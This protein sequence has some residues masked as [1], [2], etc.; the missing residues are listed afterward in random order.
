MTKAAAKAD[1][2]HG[3]MVMEAVVVGDADKGK[4]PLKDKVKLPLFWRR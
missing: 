4:F 1:S 2:P 3:G